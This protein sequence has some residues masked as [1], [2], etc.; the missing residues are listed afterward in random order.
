M[1]QLQAAGVPFTEVEQERLLSSGPLSTRNDASIRYRM[2]NISHVMEERGWPI[3]RAYS[4]APQVGRNVKARIH[5]ILNERSDTLDAVRALAG[6]SRG[7]SVQLDDVLNSLKRLKSMI[8]ALSPEQASAP[9]I[10]HNDPPE[11]IGFVR[12]DFA[13]VTRAISDIEEAFSQE[14]PDQERVS[15]RLHTLMAFGLK[16]ALWAGERVTDFAKAGAVAAG[17]GAGLSLS[18]IGGQVIEALQNIFGYLF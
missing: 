12:S 1:L 14:G 7:A 6:N 13:E 8:S 4:P 18:G 5:V 2:R 10:G 3:L 11:A 17:T 15:T 16:C 9:G